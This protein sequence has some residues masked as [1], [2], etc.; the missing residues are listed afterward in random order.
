[1]SFFKRL[2]G[3]GKKEPASLRGSE[4]GQTAEQQSS[5]RDHMEAEMQRER[6]RRAGPAATPAEAVPSLSPAEREESVIALVTGACRGMNL[7]TARV[8]VIT[9]EGA[10]V[11]TLRFNLEERASTDLDVGRITRDEESPEVLATIV[12]TELRRQMGA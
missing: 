5:T 12:V 8:D 10:T 3:G 4:L 11:P 9:L 7:Q 2:F 6:E 1:V